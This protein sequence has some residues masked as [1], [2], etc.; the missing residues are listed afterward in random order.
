MSAVLL[1][2]G[3]IALVGAV[4]VAVRMPG[5]PDARLDGEAPA[6]LVSPAAGG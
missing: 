6:E 1:V 5:R 2:C 4:L 3:A